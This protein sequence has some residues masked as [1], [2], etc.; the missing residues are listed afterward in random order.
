MAQ[1]SGILAGHFLGAHAY[2]D[3]AVHFTWLLSGVEHKA[4]RAQCLRILS[5]R[6]SQPHLQSQVVYSWVVEAGGSQVQGQSPWE[7]L[8]LGDVVQGHSTCLAWAKLWAP[9]SVPTAK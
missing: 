7:T 3:I 1:S 4:R 8:E 5:K 6:K 9:F 2:P